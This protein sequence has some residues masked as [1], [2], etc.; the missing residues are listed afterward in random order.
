MHFLLPFHIASGDV[1][2]T[3]PNSWGHFQLFLPLLPDVKAAI[4]SSCPIYNAEA[5]QPRLSHLTPVSLKLSPLQASALI[6]SSPFI[7]SHL[8]SLPS[9]DPSASQPMF[10]TSKLIV[11]TFSTLHNFFSFDSFHFPLFS[12]SSWPSSA[13]PGDNL[14]ITFFQSHT[15]VSC[16]CQKPDQ[17][18]VLYQV[19]A[20]SLM[21]MSKFSSFSLCNIK[22]TTATMK[23]KINGHTF[24]FTSVT[25]QPH[26]H[27]GFR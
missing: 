21:S 26:A 7:Q 11:F 18:T 8:P 23:N 13:L 24:L 3:D 12:L 6:P 22:I 25:S 15:R 27:T 2:L 20:V 4:K 1:L 5:F 14:F 17:A 16:I 19:R 10:I 9:S